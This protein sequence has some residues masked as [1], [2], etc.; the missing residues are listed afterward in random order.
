MRSAS[1]SITSE[2][3]RPSTMCTSRS[4]SS[5]MR[6]SCVTIRIAVPSSTVSSLN[7]RTT[8]RVESWSSA[9]VGSSASTSF[10]RLASA[11]A[12]ATRCRW[13]PDSERG[14]WL[15]RWP[16][17]SRSS[18]AT[19]R[20]AHLRRREPAGKLQRH[21]DVLV[22]RQR[23]EQIVHLE[24]EADLA[25]HPHQFAGAE[26]RQVAAEHLDAGPPAASAARRSASAAWSCRT[27]TGRSSR[28]AVRAGPRARYRTAPG[29]APRPRRRRS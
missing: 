4:A 14:L 16:S 29:S 19:P 15:M 28:S 9:A 27:P 7:R 8:L 23:L 20:L 11:R 5:M 24:D 6:W 26:P 2:T 13:P 17:P 12:I 18:I 1:L 10:G 25:P 21:L 22:G 3:M